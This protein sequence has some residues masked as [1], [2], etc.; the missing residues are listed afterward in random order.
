MILTRKL[1]KYYCAVLNSS[2]IKQQRVV[3]RDSM[4]GGDFAV[5]RTYEGAVATKLKWF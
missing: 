3:G 1:F 4:A 2:W 5:T